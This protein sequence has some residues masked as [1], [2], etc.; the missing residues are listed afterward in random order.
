MSEPQKDPF[1]ISDEPAF[2][3]NGFERDPSESTADRRINPTSE[4]EKLRDTV[5]N[6]PHLDSP[7]GE[8]RF[9]DWLHQKRQL[10][11][12][13]GNLFSTIVASVAGGLFAVAGAFL[14]YFIAPPGSHPGSFV[15]ILF[16][17]VSEEL[18]KQS[19]MIYLLEKHPYRIFSGYQFI[20]AALGSAL[21]FAVLEN[22][23]YTHVYV[24]PS[25]VPD[26]A[27]FVRFR[28]SVCTTLHVCC[29]L[30]ASLGLRKIWT[31]CTLQ[32]R[33]AELLP[34]FRYF[35]IAMGVHGTYNL[36]A[37]LADPFLF[38]HPSVN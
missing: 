2:Q 1:S 28:W 6:E 15:A 11:S 31:A 33:P 32:N 4:L 36:F 7:V 38:S 18:L 35:A 30:I 9:A 24:S 27:L 22:L 21:V 34:A 8:E 25:Q 13:R 3:G 23:L 5:W 26:F 20:F 17:P 10:C 16:A 14:A 12:E 29:S 37:T 19:G